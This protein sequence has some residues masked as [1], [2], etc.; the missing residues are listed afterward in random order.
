M[1]NAIARKSCYFGISGGRC[2]CRGEEIYCRET[3]I[4][5]TLEK[6]KEQDFECSKG[7]TVM[8]K[9]VRG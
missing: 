9:T 5:K 6:A 3:E 2:W 4:M 8:E 7:N 1:S